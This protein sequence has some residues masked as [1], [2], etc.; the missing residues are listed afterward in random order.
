MLQ[1]RFA[2]LFAFAATFLL[3]TIRI[4][5]HLQSLAFHTKWSAGLVGF[6]IAMEVV[7][8]AALVLLVTGRGQPVLLLCIQAGAVF[9][10]YLVV[11]Q[12]WG[13]AGTALCASVLLAAPL[14][15]S[16]VLFAVVAVGDAVLAGY[17]HPSA[18]MFAYALF[19]NV[20]NGFAIFAIVRLAQLVRQ[21]HEDGQRLADVEVEAERLRAADRLSTD[22]GTQL[23]T[24][25]GQTRDALASPTV[26]HGRLTV[27]GGLAHRAAADA[28][29]IADIHRSPR[30]VGP[31][32]RRQPPVGVE[33]R[34]ARWAHLLIVADFLATS[35][36]NMLWDGSAFEFTAA[37]IVILLA[38]ALQLH[39][40]SPREGGGAP[41]WWRLALA[42]Q[43]GLVVGMTLFPAPRDEI[44]MFLLLA[45]GTAAVRMRPPWSWATP[46]AIAVACFAYSQHHEG[47]WTGGYTA[48]SALYWAAVIYALHNL[49][50]ITR[51]LHATRDELTRVAVI[52]ERLRLAR[53]IH[54]LLGFHLSA[55]KLKI[56]LALRAR[57]TDPAATRG[58]LKQAQH[59]AEQALTEVRTFTTAGDSVSCRDELSAARALLEAWGAT[60]TVSNDAG[61]LPRD[62]DNLMGI[63]VREAATNIIRHARP[64]TCTF[65]ITAAEGKVRVR[66]ANDGADRPHVRADPCPAA[67]LANLRARIE[68]LGGHL[69][70]DTEHD[71]FTLTASVAIDPAPALP[72]APT[73]RA[74]CTADDAAV[75]VR[76][77][78]RLPT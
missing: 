6:C 33:L 70:A 10:P 54:D 13:L 31:A 75:T 19:V 32:P 37:H 29:A 66:V 21:T 60:V 45:G 49:P 14:R 46:A 12:G 23:S 24:L 22:V 78:D 43:V 74:K 34:F 16:W 61:P 18:L 27:L 53:D 55:I 15:A 39:I 69:T 41:R 9:A 35:V 68:T 65:E 77:A 30:P 56:E 38:A 5:W 62:V 64:E 73:G 67:G 2:G 26:D 47:V 36:I 28:R 72:M 51:R 52:T 3:F 1:P 50:E 71:T 7:L 44:S 48:A 58:H 76:T 20:A 25:V 42:T 63:I 11:G 59:S 4:L 57:E 40:G 8:A 17:F